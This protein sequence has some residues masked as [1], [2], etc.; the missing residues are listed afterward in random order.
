MSAKLLRALIV[1]GMFVLSLSPVDTSPQKST[2]TYGVCSTNGGGC[3][4]D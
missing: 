4:V 2:G 1:M 3:P